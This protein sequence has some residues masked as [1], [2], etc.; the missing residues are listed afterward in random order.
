MGY[1]MNR[2]QKCNIIILDD[3]DRCPLC[4]HVSESD[5]EK[6]EN[7]YPN[8]IE[9]TRKFRF[10]ENLV[11]FLSILVECLLL[12]INYNIHTRVQWAFITGLVLVYVNVV[13]RM[14][15]IGK[16]GYL[17]QA[18]SFV[19]LAIF[20]MLG[21][22]YLTGYKKWSLD[23]VLPGGILVLDLALFVLTLANRNGWQSYL[24]PQILLI[25]L[26]L[27][28]VVL[29]ETGVIQFPYL[30]WTALAASVFLFLGTLILGD[31]RARTELK[32]RFHI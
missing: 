23:Y 20:L 15:L 24:M 13:L 19:A 17:F 28:P 3:T 30:A 18:L 25:I 10:V 5:G 27:V 21:I 29:S 31:R 12:F 9:V 22:D 2:C 8:A 1:I 16:N 11:L 4:Q 6:V 7:R 32:R 26:S 14:T